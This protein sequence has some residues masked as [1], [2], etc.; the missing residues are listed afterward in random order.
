MGRAVS[1][2]GYDEEDIKR[3][4]RKAHH[5]SLFDKKEKVKIAQQLC[6]SKKVIKMIEEAESEIEIEKIMHDA[7]VGLIK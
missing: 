2:K 1:I 5:R 6:Y 3:A 4:D 7:R